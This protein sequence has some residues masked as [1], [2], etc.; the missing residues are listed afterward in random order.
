MAA[1][2]NV[3]KYDNMFVL[4]RILIHLSIQQKFVVLQV[5][6]K[7]S[8]LSKENNVDTCFGKERT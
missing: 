6:S 1:K 2:S 3:F 4:Y 8:V 5:N 7:M